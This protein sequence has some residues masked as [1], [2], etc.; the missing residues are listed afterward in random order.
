MNISS[1][2]LMENEDSNR[3]SDRQLPNQPINSLNFITYY[4]LLIHSFVFFKHHN[5]VSI[6]SLPLHHIAIFS[7]RRQRATHLGLLQG[8]LS[9][10]QPDHKGHRHKQADRQPHVKVGEVSRCV[11][12]LRVPVS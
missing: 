3:E 11:F 8:H 6:F 9:A 1:M 7:R 2:I 10:V 5:N 12:E 4:S